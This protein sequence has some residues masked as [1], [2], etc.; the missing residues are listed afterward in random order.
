MTLATVLLAASLSLAADA[1]QTTQ[2]RGRAQTVTPSQEQIDA[3]LKKR[4]ALRSR[5]EVRRQT[6]LTKLEAAR[7]AFVSKQQATLEAAN[8][9]TLERIKVEK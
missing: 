6:A 9:K 8:R 7:Q 3:T 2:P 5:V 4:K 1:V